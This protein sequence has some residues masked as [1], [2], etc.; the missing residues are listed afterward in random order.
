MWRSSSDSSLGWKKA[1]CSCPK[2]WPEP[3]EMVFAPHL[4]NIRSVSRCIISGEA[5]MVIEGFSHPR[6]HVY[7]QH[8][9]LHTIVD[10]HSFVD[11]CQ[12]R[13]GAIRRHGCPHHDA[14]RLLE[15]NMH[16]VV[17]RKVTWV[18]SIDPVIV[19]V[20]HGL[21]SEDFFIEP[22]DSMITGSLSS[23]T[24]PLHFLQHL[25]F[26]VKTRLL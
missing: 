25:L 11:E 5:V 1:T 23:T 16:P 7:L 2:F 18:R 4:G 3:A 13:F 24:G 26:P 12:W 6:E 9:Q 20:G 22:D 19:S 15:A 14:C 8:F 21:D 10:L 17:F